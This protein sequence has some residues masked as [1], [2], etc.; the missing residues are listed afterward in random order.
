[1][2]KKKT[3]EKAVTAQ[4]SDLA[5]VV[6]SG[7]SLQGQ[8]RKRMLAQ[9]IF[10]LFKDDAGNKF[11]PTP[12]QVEIFDAIVTK[13]YFRLGVVTP[14]QYGK[15]DIVAMAI[16]VR[17]AVYRERFLLLGS[18]KGQSSIIMR[19]AIQHCF[20]NPLF[21]SLIQASGKLDTLQRE[22]NRDRIDFVFGGG[23]R[24]LS[25][26]AM[27][28]LVKSKTRG[29]LL[30]EGEQN[31][32]IDDSPLIPDAVTD[33]IY[34]MVGGR[35]D[36]FILEL[37]NAINRNHFHRLM[38]TTPDSI[39]LRMGRIWINYQRAL[40]EGRFTS[41]FLT[42]IRDEVTP[43]FF[44]SFY[45]CQ[46]PDQNEIDAS[47]YR[48]LFLDS[49]IEEAVK[50]ERIPDDP[51]LKEQLKSIRW[52]YASN[53]N[54]QLKPKLEMLAEGLPSP[55]R[56]DA[57]AMTFY[58]YPPIPEG[59]RRLGVDVGGGTAENVFF[60]R[61]PAKSKILETNHINDTMQVA[62]Q[63]MD[64]IHRHKF[65]PE[66]VFIDMNGL[67]QGTF[68][69]VREQ[70]K[71]VVGVQGSIKP[72]NKDPHY[73][74]HNKRTEMYW[75]LKN[76]CLGDKLKPPKVKNIADQIIH[77]PEAPAAAWFNEGEMEQP[78]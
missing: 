48:D 32:V 18:T 57:L 52:R 22:L 23:F 51:E 72:D 39:G 76:W 8:D 40:Q 58:D 2:S 44:R 29:A 43:Q 60:E 5:R 1:M 6:S 30:G 7:G 77:G 64:M 37:G 53:G 49:E 34:R 63:T 24:C 12:T 28:G 38:T 66:N 42:W 47:G 54:V 33:F 65:E 59:M 19:R 10:T 11:I 74:F 69:R 56:S 9:M 20:D 3:A 68:D 31:V 21:K 55:D 67:G 41:D 13:Q 70:G 27:T 15:T 62:G 71:P 75:R 73:K 16:V 50:L 17:A 78:K 46:F 45:E 4:L 26:Q 25:A 61:A 36:V 35:Q 14:T